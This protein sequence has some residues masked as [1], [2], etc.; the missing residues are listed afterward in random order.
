[1]MD[2]VYNNAESMKALETLAKMADKKSGDLIKQVIDAKDLVNHEFK[3]GMFVTEADEQ[4][5]ENVEDNTEDMLKL[6]EAIAK[7]ATACKSGEELLAWGNDDKKLDKKLA[8]LGSDLMR[9]CRESFETNFEIVE[10]FLIAATTESASGSSF[11]AG[12]E[13]GVW[14]TYLNGLWLGLKHK[15][16]DALGRWLKSK[17]D[18]FYDL[19]EQMTGY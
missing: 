13:Y 15:K 3:D 9:D 12:V 4:V 11:K 8:K 1:M 14:Q 19:Y 6:G 10:D 16:D 5:D 18:D 2:A 17:V 7:C